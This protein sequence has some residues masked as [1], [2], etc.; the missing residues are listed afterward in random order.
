ML[1]SFFTKFQKFLSS[2]QHQLSLTSNNYP[3]SGLPNSLLSNNDP[4]N[5]VLPNSDLPNR[6]LSNNSVSN[7]DLPNSVLPNRLFS[8][9]DL[10]SSVLPNSDLQN[11]VLPNSFY[12]IVFYRIMLVIIFYR[13]TTLAHFLLLRVNTSTELT[14]LTI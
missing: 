4:S 2:L 3:N 1:P 11:R 8:N 12:R 13:K 9:S 10:P 7:N 14:L 5:R 6:A